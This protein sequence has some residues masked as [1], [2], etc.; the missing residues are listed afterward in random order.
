MDKNMIFCNKILEKKVYVIVNF[1]RF[2]LFAKTNE[3]RNI[4]WTHRRKF[5]WKTQCL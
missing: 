1:P 2:I 4:E 5:E 3:T